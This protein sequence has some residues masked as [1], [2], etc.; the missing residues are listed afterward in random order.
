MGSS[1]DNSLV[2]PQFANGFLRAKVRADTAG[3]LPWLYMGWSGLEEEGVYVFLGDSIRNSFHIEFELPGEPYQVFRMDDPTIDFDVGEEWYIEGGVVGDQITMKVWEVGDP[4]PTAP[5]LT[6]TDS[7]L[8][9][10]QFGVGTNIHFNAIP[11]FLNVTFDD[12][13]FTPA[14]AGDFNGN[15][16]VNGADFLAWQRGESP[17]PLSQSDLAYWEANYGDAIPLT[18]TSTAI[19]EPT[20]ALLLVFGV[21]TAACWRRRGIA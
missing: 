1:W 3:S 10:G 21:V 6:I 12:I 8:S 5:Q 4:E 15:D 14:L 2:D 7:T 20:A 11:G 17:N 9:T 18:A 19:P 16:V 13:W